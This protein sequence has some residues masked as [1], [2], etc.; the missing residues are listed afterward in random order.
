M[1]FVQIILYDQ[2][3]QIGWSDDKI[4]IIFINILF[5]IMIKIEIRSEGAMI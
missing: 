5:Q 3:E 2:S 4:S 1:Y